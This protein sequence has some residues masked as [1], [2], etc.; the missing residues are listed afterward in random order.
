MILGF[1]NGKFYRIH[2]DSNERFSDKYMNYCKAGGAVHAIELQC[3]NE[4]MIDYLI[5][6]F[7]YD[8]S[9]FSYISLHVPDLIYI[10]D[11]GSNRILSK[12]KILAQ[13]YNINNFVFHTDKNTDWDFL[14]GNAD[15]PISVENMD[16][17][18]EK[19]KFIEDIK[20]ILDKYDYKLTLDLQHCFVND[21]SMKL[22][23]DF[24]D[25]FKGKIAE[26][27]I[28]GYDS[29]FLHYPL[30]KTKQDQIINSLIYKNIPIIIESTFDEIGDHE[31]ELDY[32]KN[33][34]N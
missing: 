32:I 28:S 6:I 16:E 31:K 9:Y 22:A 21:R 8:L 23:Q 25:V 5:D 10:D 11:E 3:R 34:I 27:H 24:Q 29:E 1:G 19:G 26:Y 15:L 20:L 7:D 14:S 12:L 13:K 2:S 17:R 18:K 33:R 4:A 30:F